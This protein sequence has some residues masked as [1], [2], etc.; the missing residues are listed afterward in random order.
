MGKKMKVEG[1]ES[2]VHFTQL[3]PLLQSEKL[4]FYQ[5]KKKKHGSFVLEGKGKQVFQ[6][7][8][9]D[10]PFQMLSA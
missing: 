2:M 7:G 5:K 9:S 10:Q 6:G 1:S 4:H 3:L 8:D